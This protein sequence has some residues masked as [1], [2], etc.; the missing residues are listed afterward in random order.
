M[1][2]QCCTRNNFAQFWRTVDFAGLLCMHSPENHG[3]N[4]FPDI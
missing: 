1:E 4:I 2:S 3:I